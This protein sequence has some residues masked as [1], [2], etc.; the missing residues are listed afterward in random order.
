MEPNYKK[1]K[2][3]IVDD[4]RFIQKVL[5]DILQ[6]D[7]A[8]EVIGLAKNGEE[9]ITMVKDLKPDVVTMDVE[10]PRVSGIDA[11][12]VIMDESPVPVIMLSSLTSDGAQ[13]TLNALEFGAVDFVQ[14]PTGVFDL[15]S[16]N[17]KI[18]IINKVKIA[19]RAKIHKSNKLSF[20]SP[21]PSP[22][23]LNL[24][25]FKPSND[26]TSIVAIGISTGGPKALQYIIPQ[27]PKNITASFLVVQHMPP[28]FTKS[29]ADRLNN[30][31]QVTVKEAEDGEVV[32][33]GFVYIAPGDYHL[34][35]KE[36]GKDVIII[37]GKEDSVSGHRPSVD[38]MFNSIAESKITNNI[39]GVVMTGMGSDGTKGAVQ[40]KNSKGSFIIAQD[41]SSSIVYGMPK[42]VAKAGVV[43]KIVSLDRIIDTI[44]NRVGV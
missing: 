34:R 40:L 16:N 3:L 42:S 7:D 26:K 38:V 8:I 28:N 17:N 15:N 23:R 21:T 5:M 30:I 25:S 14:K 6:S 35:V 2:V 43:D 19:S 39:V 1:I 18:E 24:N 27:I 13:S 29:L 37:L 20:N 36:I 31:S 32:K 9:A 41:E 11:L 22:S 12:K 10:M 44:I 4:S 33:P